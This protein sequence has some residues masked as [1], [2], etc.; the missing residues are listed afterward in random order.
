MKLLRTLETLEARETPAALAT[1]ELPPAQL[2]QPIDLPPVEMPQPISPPIY[3]DPIYAIGAPAGSRGR[4]RTINADQ[5]VRQDFLAFNGSFN[6]EVK[7]VLGDVNG[8]GTKDIIVG[9]GAGGG[10][11]VQVWDGA[12]TQDY[13]S[14]GP[15]LTV[16]PRIHHDFFAFSE[17]FNGGVSL[18]SADVDGDGKDDIIVGAGAGGG[19]HVKVFSGQTGQLLKQFF[20]FDQNYSGGVNLSAGEFTSDDKADIVVGS[21]GGMKATVAVFSGEDA[22]LVKRLEPYGSF[23]GGVSVGII[24]NVNP[25]AD[26]VAGHFP[27]LVTSPGVGGGPHVKVYA[28]VTSSEGP[29]LVAEFM[30][31]DPTFSGGVS[32]ATADVNGDYLDDIITGAGV[33]GTPHIR[34]FHPV[35]GNLLGQRLAQR[36]SPS[37]PW[38]NSGVM[39][40]S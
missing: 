32:L 33:G 19:P 39:L 9:A 3:N 20:A 35:T 5:S 30:A 2:P 26:Y 25:L 38:Y 24:N 1:T 40:G 7:A 21:N 23:T 10:P 36:V 28:D 37:D 31:Y 14:G 16:M 6:G 12:T 29:T 18:S 22:S 11:R 8:D 13:F 34:E 17:G 27:Y 4:V 15:I